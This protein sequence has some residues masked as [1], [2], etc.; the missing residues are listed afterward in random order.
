MQEGPLSSNLNDGGAF[1]FKRPLT[2][3]IS[4]RYWDEK[5]DV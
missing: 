3:A 5:G 1:L 2:A 4:A